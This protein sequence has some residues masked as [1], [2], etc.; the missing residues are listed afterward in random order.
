MIDEAHRDGDGEI[1]EWEFP[2]IMK[3]SDDSAQR[4]KI[5]IIILGVVALL[6][7]AL[8]CFVLRCGAFGLICF[9]LR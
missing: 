9:G 1:N 7:L 3:K 5:F 2:R 8:I 6:C 4:W